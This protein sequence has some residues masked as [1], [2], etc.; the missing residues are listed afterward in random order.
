M[1]KLKV[2]AVDRTV[3]EVDRLT[4][5]PKTIRIY[6][7]YCY[8]DPELGVEYMEYSEWSLKRQ[9]Y[10]NKKFKDFEVDEE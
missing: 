2:R 1:V 6:E 4:L 7:P 9:Q 5:E 10:L 3:F 8:S